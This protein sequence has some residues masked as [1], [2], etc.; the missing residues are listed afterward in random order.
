MSEGRFDD[1]Y[2]QRNVTFLSSRPDAMSSKALK[3]DENNDG[4]KNN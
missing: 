1:Q 3:D 4:G 2:S